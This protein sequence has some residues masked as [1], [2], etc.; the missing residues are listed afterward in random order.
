MRRANAKRM[1]SNTKH[2]VYLRPPRVTESKRRDPSAE[3]W[4]LQTVSVP[5]ITLFPPSLAQ[6]DGA[7]LAS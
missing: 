6:V 1:E 5:D 2:D 4:G 3:T 7:S